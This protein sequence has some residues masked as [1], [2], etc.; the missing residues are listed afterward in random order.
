MCN[1]PQLPASIVPWWPD[2]SAGQGGG[3]GGVIWDVQMDACAKALCH[4]WRTVAGRAL[5]LVL[6]VQR[7]ELPGVDDDDQC[8]TIRMP[9]L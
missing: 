5:E 9:N 8:H 6:Q 1:T 3:L 2:P 4:N 7:S